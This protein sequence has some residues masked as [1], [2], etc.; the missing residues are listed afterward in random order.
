M[1]KKMNIK[2]SPTEIYGKSQQLQK[3]RRQTLLVVTILAAAVL[4]VFI[5]VKFKKL[6]ER[7]EKEK[8]TPLVRTELIQRKDIQ[9]IVS[10]YGTV[11]PHLQVEIVPQ[12]SGKIVYVNPSFKAGGFIKAGETLLQ[13]DPRDYEL[14]LQQAEAVVAEAQVRLDL[15]KAEA[16]VAR[17]EWD[18]INPGT[19]PSSPLVLREPQIRQAQA[20]LES[21]KAQLATAELNLERTKVSLPVDVRIIDERADLGQYVMTGQS[22]GSAYGI[23]IVE[24]EVPI[25]DW[26]LAWFDI[27]DD[28]ISFNGQGPTTGETLASVEADFAGKRHSWTG[29][30]IRTTGQ[31][32]ETSRLVSVVV[33][34][35]KPFEN[36]DSRPPLMPGTF[37]EVF[38]KGNFLKNAAA[39]PRYAVHNGNE[40]WV[41]NNNRLHIQTLQIVRRD[42]DFI[43][44]VSGIEDNTIIV[45]SSL[46]AVTNGM[47]IRTESGQKPIPQESPQK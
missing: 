22:L 12:V 5:L 18:Q 19:E 33:E 2:A 46:D 42:T 37:V 36:T 21:T 17:N 1:R 24:I 8:L 20:Q 25:E 30:V 32:D 11:K 31:V 16:Q 27:P 35:S 23:E 6:P 10:G 9:M 14:A 28:S 4:V 26:E 7:V 15:E 44:V 13:I 41:V 39:I 3:G 34:V 45:V 29:R 47:E 40:I 38:I 43:Y